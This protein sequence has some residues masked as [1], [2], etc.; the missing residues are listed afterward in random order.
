MVDKI[1]YLACG[2]QAC[3]LLVLFGVYLYQQLQAY[4]V[5]MY[6][7][8]YSQS[9]TDDT[10]QLLAVCKELPEEVG[11]SIFKTLTGSDIPNETKNTRQESKTI[12]FK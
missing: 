5:K 9:Q 1:I 12:G 6:K 8:G 2:F 11:N 4:G 10:K 3:V 7:S